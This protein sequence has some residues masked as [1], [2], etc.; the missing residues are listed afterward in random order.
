ML[1]VVMW[2]NKILLPIPLPLKEWDLFRQHTVGGWD[3]YV[4]PQTWIAFIKIFFI[5]CGVTIARKAIEH[6]GPERSFR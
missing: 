2:Y 6:F 4:G 5:I 1:V 3:I